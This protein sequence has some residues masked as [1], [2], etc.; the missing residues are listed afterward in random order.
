METIQSW[1]TVIMLGVGAY[2]FAYI[3]TALDTVRNDNEEN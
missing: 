2:C 1:M 3:I